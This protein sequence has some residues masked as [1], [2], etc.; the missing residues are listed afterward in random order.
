MKIGPVSLP[1]ANAVPIPPVIV[2][3]MEAVV[4]TDELDKMPS[5]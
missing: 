2:A 4:S 1:K 5:S 3:T